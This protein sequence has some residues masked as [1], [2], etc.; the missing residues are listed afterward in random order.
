MDCLEWHSVSN[1]AHIERYYTIQ[2]AWALGS[3]A[4]GGISKCHLHTNMHKS[5]KLSCQNVFLLYYTFIPWITTVMDCHLTCCRATKESTKK[6][7]F[8][9]PN[10][11]ARAR[12]W[13]VEFF[14]CPLQ[15]CWSKILSHCTSYIRRKARRDLI[16]IVPGIKLCS[17]SS[18]TRDDVVF[19]FHSPPITGAHSIV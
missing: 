8:K 6:R 15:M 1:G 3:D 5:I 11:R 13:E 10:N 12:A 2:R 16:S 4:F 9:N 7:N 14:S 18:A 19:L 17:A